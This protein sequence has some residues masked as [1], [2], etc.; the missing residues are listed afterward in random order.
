MATS[1][2]ARASGRREGGG[3]PMDTGTQLEEPRTLVID[4]QR[5]LRIAS[6]TREVLAEARRIAPR[7]DG[8]AHLRQIHGRICG[9]LRASLPPELYAELSDLTPEVEDGSVEDLVLAHAEILGWLEGL[10]QAVRLSL[11]QRP[12]H[13]AA[14]EASAA[15]SRT[16]RMRPDPSYL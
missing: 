6:V 11:A 13:E 9:E 15:G 14:P 1:G 8:A 7:L 10:F 12:R 5:L 16:E 3:D 2:I 4:P